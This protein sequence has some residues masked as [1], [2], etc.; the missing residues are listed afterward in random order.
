MSEATLQI[1]AI[2]TLL[3]REGRPFTM[4]PG[5]RA[6]TM[7]MPL[8]STLAGFLRTCIG[9][10]AG[11]SSPADWREI[12]SRVWVRGPLMTWDGS[13]ILHAPA[14]ALVYHPNRD[15]KK[16]MD[17]MPLRPI[18][19]PAGAGT[20]IP[21]GMIPVQPRGEAKP[22]KGFDFW[23]WAL[24]ER[25]LRGEHP[26]REELAAIQHLAPS[27]D[28]RVHVEIDPASLGSREGRLF[29]T[30][31]VAH[32]KHV[33][34]PR[35][36]RP[37]VHGEYSLLCRVEGLEEGESL[38]GPETL[39]GENRLASIAPASVEWPCCP[40]DL[41]DKLRQATHVRMI[42]A[43]PA[44]FEWGWM[45]KWLDKTTKEGSP[46]GLDVRLKLVAAAV[47]RR[48]PVSGW[49]MENRRPKPVRWM[50][51]AGSV[52]FFE[53][54]GGNPGVLAEEGWLAPVSDDEE[55]EEPHRPVSKNRDDGFG[56]ALWGVWNGKEEPE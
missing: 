24:V 10:L 48:Q 12:A 22:A 5:G 51:P 20:D 47:P 33:F 8:P 56:L 37:E 25:W 14:D 46:P 6:D 23:S 32:E 45:P 36:D 28:Q 19:P 42:L 50:A 9:K 17:I 30:R 29:S 31:M 27:V 55:I 13:V 18:A 34:R 40:P 44:I 53:V 49:D 52:Y 26:T 39:G 43:T 7:L 4:D 38:T 2:D 1:R 41:R 35:K 54:K 15:N 3:F 16:V 11:A 21:G